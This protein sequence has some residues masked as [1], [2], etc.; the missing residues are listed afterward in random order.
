MK[1][2][3]AAGGA[4]HGG[5]DRLD[6]RGLICRQGRPVRPGADLYHPRPPQALLDAQ[7]DQPPIL[8]ALQGPPVDA[9]RVEPPAGQSLERAALLRPQ[10][11]PVF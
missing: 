2:V 3:L 6:R 8:E 9:G 7:P 5:D 11:G 4:V 1:Q 10:P